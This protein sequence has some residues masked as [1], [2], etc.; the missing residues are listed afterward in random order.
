MVPIIF[1]VSLVTFPS[2][3]GQILANSNGTSKDI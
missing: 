1:A 2:I 3:L